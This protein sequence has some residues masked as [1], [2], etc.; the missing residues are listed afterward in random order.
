MELFLIII[1]VGTVLSIVKSAKQKQQQEQRKQQQQEQ[2][3]SHQPPVQDYGAKMPVFEWERPDVSAPDI[4]H[5]E[6]ETEASNWPPDFGM[7]FPVDEPTVYEAAPADTQYVSQEGVS[8]EGP[9]ASEQAFHTYGVQT[10]SMHPTVS[11][12]EKAVGL[13][14]ALHQRAGQKT[15][16][17]IN[18]V[19]RSA[20]MFSHLDRDDAMKAIVLGEVFGA[21]KGKRY[22]G[23]PWENFNRR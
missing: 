8:Q 18:Q 11:F 17:T 7:I 15:S 2:G 10:R 16:T 14:P 12:D 21:P 20:G 22:A 19:K 6:Q 5:Y 1:L 3:Q 13:K 4:E 9:Y 23:A